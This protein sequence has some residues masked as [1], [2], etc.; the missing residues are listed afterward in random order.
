M[1]KDCNGIS[2]AFPNRNTKPLEVVNVNNIFNYNNILPSV[3]TY[4]S[5]NYI[6]NL[7][8]GV[9]TR[10]FRAVPELSSKDVIF[11]EYTLS[12]VDPDPICVKVV[13]PNGQF[14]DAKNNY[15]LMGLEYEIPL[16]VQVDLAYWNECAGMGTMPQKGD[17]V[18]IPLSNKLYEVNS[19]CEIRGFMEQITGYKCNLVKYQPTASRLFNIDEETNLSLNDTLSKYTMGVESVFG[20]EIKDDIEVLTSEQQLSPYLNTSRAEYSVLSKG[21]ETIIDDVYAANTLFAKSYYD[22]SSVN[23][24]IAITYTPK[25]VYNIDTERAYYAWVNLKKDGRTFDVTNI[26]RVNDTT[27]KLRIKTLQSIGMNTTINVF[28]TESLNFIAKVIDLVDGVYTVEISENSANNMKKL[29]D[30]W[31]DIKGYKASIGTITNIINSDTIKI[32]VVNRKHVYVNINNQIFEYMVEKTLD[33]NTWYGIVVNV[34]NK[35][36]KVGL[37]IWTQ[38]TMYSLTPESLQLEL[39]AIK[40]WDITPFTSDVFTYN[41]QKSKSLLTNIRVYNLVTVEPNNQIDELLSIY[42]KH[43]DK[44]ILIDNG[45]IVY[46]MTYIASNR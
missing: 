23:D 40:S 18:Y 10:W 1:S 29:K 25:D 16:E 45:D 14:P 30:K 32:D 41:I 33:A 17:I 9:D 38:N 27:F 20:E 13:V 8:L 31:Y 39:L 44:C 42:T 11:L 43:S 2:S 24:D 26:E 22:F 28:K 46:N 21:V 3:Q 6:A 37:N 19:S 12:S 7:M 15:D 4:T 35:L 36:G 5:L 34:S